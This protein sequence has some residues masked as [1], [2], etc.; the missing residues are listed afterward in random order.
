MNKSDDI[1]A[2]VL[3][4]AF[5]AAGLLL[6]HFND[7]QL[8]KLM[9]AVRAGMRDPASAAGLDELLA[10]FAMGPPNTTLVRRMVNESQHEELKDFLFGTFFFKEM[11]IEDN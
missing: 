9:R 8:L 1:K 2:E 3:T 6:S 7:A 10:A 4:R 5:M 11:D